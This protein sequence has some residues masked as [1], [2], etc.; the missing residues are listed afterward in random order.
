MRA[1]C[2]LL[3]ITFSNLIFA[4]QYLN[5]CSIRSSD[6]LVIDNVDY[7]PT[8]S[9]MIL[10]QSIMINREACGFE[11]L[12]NT[13][14]LTVTFKVDTGQCT[15]YFE[16]TTAGQLTPVTGGNVLSAVRKVPGKHC[17]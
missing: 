15:L 8:S 2:I 5:K 11:C 7:Q 1:S 4:D 16:Q 17:C 12:T 14:C 10:Y 3:F 13:F 9:N 6:Y